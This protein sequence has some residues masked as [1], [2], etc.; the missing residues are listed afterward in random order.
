M[1]IYYTYGKSEIKL[2][3]PIFSYCFNSEQ[4]YMSQSHREECQTGT[5]YLVLP[6][7]AFVKELM[8]FIELIEVI[9]IHYYCSFL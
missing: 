2:E 1:Y 8:A 5:V 7:R 4:L 6:A 3:P 9:T